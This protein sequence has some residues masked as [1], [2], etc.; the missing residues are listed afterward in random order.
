MGMVYFAH[1]LMAE[2]LWSVIHFR[3]EK[4]KWNLKNP[5]L[6]NKVGFFYETIFKTLRKR[7]SSLTSWE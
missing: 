6:K 4:Q 7:K 5:T 3:E 2:I 1:L